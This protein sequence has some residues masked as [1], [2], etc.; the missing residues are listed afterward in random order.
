MLAV[1]RQW[2]DYDFYWHLAV[3][4][5]MSTT[6]TF[7]SPDRFS[8]SAFG[9]EWSAY[10]A[11]VDRV[12][13]MI[14]HAGG[15]AGLG[16]AVGALFGLCILPYALLVGRLGLR[17]QIQI[18]ALLAITGPLLPFRGARPHLVALALFGAVIWLTDH[19]FDLRKGLL[20]GLALGLWAN[21]H[22]SF[23]VGFGFMGLTLAVW[24]HQRQWAGARAA[25]LAIGLGFLLSLLSPYGLRLWALPFA[26]V[27][28]PALKSINQDWVGLRP[29]ALE[30]AGMGLLLLAAMAVGIWRAGSPRAVGALGLTLPAIQIARFT[31]FTAPL[32]CLSILEQLVER[33]PHLRAAAAPRQGR[34]AQ[35]RAHMLPWLV[36]LG[37]LL[38]LP[39]VAQGSLEDAS[40]YAL[41]QRAVDRLI[42]CGQPGPVWA[43]YNWSG[44]LLWRGAGSYTVGV[45]GRG[46]TLYSP[47][48][49]SRYVDVLEG[50]TGWQN[51]VDRS[52]ANYVLVPADGGV[53][54]G[55]TH[56]WTTV[57][58]DTEAIIAARDAAVWRCG[59][60]RAEAPS[61][62]AIIER[63]ALVAPEL[64]VEK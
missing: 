53:T 43:D 44:Y 24:L 55:A 60:P 61:A 27:A 33:H 36:L 10:S 15:V 18:M 12:F 26:T 38:L 1:A 49:L 34:A 3:G 48:I 46:E 9:Q 37:S 42:A 13:F 50:R 5:L 16:A 54:I 47:E 14:W 59:R 8:W 39:L 51:I 29:F 4:R 64:D 2:A 56:G 28:N 21:A 23:M 57:Y 31:P 32:L 30:S 62:H 35:H 25:G 22:G 63:G 17:W 41:P 6:N 40:V 52:P 7:P 20:A 58:R 45:D 19:A 11:I